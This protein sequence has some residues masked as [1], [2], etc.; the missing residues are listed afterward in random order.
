MAAP[1]AQGDET[2]ALNP[3]EVR[4]SGGMLALVRFLMTLQ[5]KRMPVARFTVGRDKEDMRVTILLN[6]PPESARRYLTLLSALEDVEA[7]EA[8]TE[9]MEVALLKVKG[10]VSWDGSAARSGIV[11]HEN[12]KTIVA[13]GDPEALE[14]WLTEVQESVE[15]VVRIGPM[16]RP[17]MG[18]A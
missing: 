1:R 13:S 9:T 12:G 10:G 11:A 2:V 16:A 17:G 4:L 7:I 14:A 6:C 18:G 5:N 3:I 15:D 8:T